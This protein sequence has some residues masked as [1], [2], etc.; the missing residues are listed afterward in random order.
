MSLFFILSAVRHQTQKKLL[1][2]K[3]LLISTALL[4]VSFVTLSTISNAQ[5]LNCG[6]GADGVYSATTNT[7]LEGGTY[8]FSS[9][10]IAAGVTVTVTGSSPLVIQCTGPVNI[11]GTLSA[12]GGNGG[13]GVTFSTFGVGGVG[14]AG[15]ANGG[16]GVYI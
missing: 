5:C 1:M 11:Q 6:N 2:K 12:N 14:V 9:F 3:R 15:G 16:D 4:I 7:T 8:N 13:D 10:S